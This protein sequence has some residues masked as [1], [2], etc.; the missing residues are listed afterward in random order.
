MPCIDA[1]AMIHHCVDNLIDDRLPAK[2]LQYYDVIVCNTKYDINRNSYSV[3]VISDYT[4]SNYC[5]MQ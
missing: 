5:D 2:T 4:C 1:H 3:L